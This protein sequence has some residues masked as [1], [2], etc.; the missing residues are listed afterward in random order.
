MLWVHNIASVQSHDNSFDERGETICRRKKIPYT[1]TNIL[2]WQKRKKRGKER[3]DEGKAD[4]ENC[5]MKKEMCRFWLTFLFSLFLLYFRRLK[6]LLQ[7]HHKEMTARTTFW[8][9]FAF[10]AEINFCFWKM[11]HSA[12]KKE[13]RLK[14]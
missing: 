8:F 1:K 3:A 14:V 11:G 12:R 7:T 9:F 13:S 2:M 4:E 6:W 10:L 5:E